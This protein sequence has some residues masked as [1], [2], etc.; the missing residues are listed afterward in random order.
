MEELEKRRTFSAARGRRF[1]LTATSAA[2]SSEMP[3]RL[4]LRHDR[5]IYIRRLPAGYEKWVAAHFMVGPAP[6]KL[7]G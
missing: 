6:S 7:W 5:K 1:M 2:R 4:P 3:L